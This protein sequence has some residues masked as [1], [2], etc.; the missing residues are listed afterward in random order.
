[1]CSRDD[2]RRTFESASKQRGGSRSVDRTMHEQHA[3]SSA[4]GEGIVRDHGFEL[5]ATAHERINA[6]GIPDETLQ[7]ANILGDAIEHEIASA[8]EAGDVCETEVDQSITQRLHRDIADASQ[9]RYE[10]SIHHRTPLNEVS[11]RSTHTP[12]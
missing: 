4:S 9:E 2:R 10:V 7:R 1:M 11:L 12:Q 3:R 8:A 5:V 6:D